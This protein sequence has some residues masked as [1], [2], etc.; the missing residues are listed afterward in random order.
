[1]Y[2]T[3]E[4][5][6]KNNIDSLVWPD[7]EEGCYAKK[8]L[9]PLIKNG[10]HYYVDNIQADIFALKVQQFVFP[11]TVVTENYK[12]SWVCSP[13]SQYITY[14]K[15]AIE[16]F[17]NPFLVKLAKLFLGGFDKMGCKGSID[18]V[19]CVNNWLFS[20]DLYPE[21]FSSEQISAI[22]T[23]LKERFP[24][25]AIVFRSLNP[26]VNGSLM[27]SLKN[28]GFHFITSRQILLTD[29]KNESIFCTRILKS[30]LKL[31]RESSYKVLDETQ[32]SADEC[33]KLLEL[34]NSL[35]ITHHSYV[36]PQINNSFMRLISKQSLLNFKVL[37]LNGSIKGVAG[38]CVR[39]GVLYSPFFG[40]EKDDPDHNVIYRLLNT[41]LILEAQKEKL[42]FHQSSGASFAKKIRRAESCLESM[43]I[44]TSH[45]PLK[46]RLTWAAFRTL[47]NWFGPLYMK[48]Y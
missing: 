46:Q 43:A 10:I 45:L 32:I 30:D 25:H 1:M 19:V 35:Y 27:H 36:N 13:Y 11:T 12:N 24:R 33:S 34:Y 21:G 47:I 20:T 41:A 5:F 39:N 3:L 16:H 7:T 9:E 15:E 26:V 14:G 42:I 2:I 22:V 8:F 6:D 4:L 37:R 31:W 48:K 44:Y 29:T 38:Y 28:L 40:Y 18:S 23:A 17:G